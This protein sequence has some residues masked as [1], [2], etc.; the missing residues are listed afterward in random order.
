MEEDKI[1]VAAVVKQSFEDHNPQLYFALALQRKRPG[2]SEEYQSH[3][4][5]VKRDEDGTL[6][7]TATAKVLNECVTAET[8]RVDLVDD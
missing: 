8:F 4:M 3:T 2:D 6:H 7:M 1:T 5:D